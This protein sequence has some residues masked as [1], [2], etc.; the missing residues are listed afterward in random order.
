MVVDLEDA[1]PSASPGQKKKKKGGEVSV[2]E[3]T[4]SIDA[5]MDEPT[6]K[7]EIK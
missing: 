2:D 6:A 4:A 1:D 3:L 7:K 5:D